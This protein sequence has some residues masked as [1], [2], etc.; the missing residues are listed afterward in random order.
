MGRFDGKVAFITG[1]SSGIGAAL[2]RE[3]ARHGAAV[4]LVARR[5]ERIDAIAAEITAAGGR[6]VAIAADVTKD[7]DQ[8]RAVAQTLSTLGHIDIAIANAGF[9]VGGPFTRLT[10]DDY[11]RQF[12]TNVFGLLRTAYATLAALR[13]TRG[14]L[15][16]VGS[17]AGHAAL[18][19]SSPYNMSKFAVRALADALHGELEPE[20]VSTVLVSPGFVASE[21]H[22][23]DNRGRR[24]ADR[25]D[26]IPPWLR[27]PA[28]TAAKQIVR[29]IACR[30]REVVVT[31]HGKLLVFASHYLPHLL[32]WFT[33]RMAKRA[34]RYRER[35]TETLMQKSP[36]PAD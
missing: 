30:R 31:V 12:E 34:I 36:P 15:V 19:G 22:Q 29:A 20:G 21:L 24:R 7:G 2:A 11:R 1:A 6:A 3:L 28:T 23:I 10:L 16:L 32:A 18:P 27:M 14:T 5:V 13:A 17:V 8:E 26:T 33:R 25:K 9:G 4:A 35:R